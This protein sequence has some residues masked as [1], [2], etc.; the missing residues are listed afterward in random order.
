MAQSQITTLPAETVGVIS[1]YLESPDLLSLRSACRALADKTSTPFQ[2][3]FFHTRHVMLE[4]RSLQ[5]LVDISRH[6]VLRYAVQVV[7]LTTDHLVAP[8]DYM[9]R[10]DYDACGI[11]DECD[12]IRLGD[13]ET[14]SLGDD[15]YE[16]VIERYRAE[17]DAYRD[18]L[19]P[20]GAW[21]RDWV[22]ALS[23]L[24]RCKAVGIDDNV[25][26][27]GALR[28]GRRIGTFPNRFVTPFQA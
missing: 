20:K 2:H 14:L 4:R 22:E 7:E 25:R 18:F 27:W 6:S 10:A 3:R 9:S 5:N 13:G 21:L 15:S 17:W 26:P 8:A 1:Q 12:G 24:P 16:A 19:L 11:N 23:N 28:L